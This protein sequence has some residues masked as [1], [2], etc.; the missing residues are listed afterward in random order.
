MANTFKDIIITPNRSSN[1]VDPKIEFRGGNVSVNTSIS[2]VVYPESNGTLSFEGSAG[3]LFSITNDLSGIIFSVN[4]ISGLPAIEVD[5]NSNIILNQFAGNVSIGTTNTAA[6]KLTVQGTVS[7]LLRLV[8]TSAGGDVDIQFIPVDSANTWTIGID[9]SDADKFKIAEHTVLGTAK[10]Y[11]TIDVNG[12]VSIG[13]SSSI[14]KFDV[15]FAAAR[16]VVIN[17][18]NSILTLKGSNDSGNPENLRL[19]ADSLLFH[20]GGTGSG[21]ERMRI[22]IGGNVMIGTTSAYTTGGTAGLTI[23][24]A[25][26]ALS[27]GANSS[28]M[29]YVRHLSDGNFQFQTGS[30]AGGANAGN[31]HLQPYG[32][33]VAIGTTSPTY[34]L[35]VLGAGSTLARFVGSAS[36]DALVRIIAANYGTEFD[37]RLFL[38]EN[39]NNGMTFEYDGVA[40]IGYIG[41]NDSI[42][43]TGSWSKRIQM[44][45]TGTEVAFMAGNVS[46]GTA[47]PTG[48]LTVYGSANNE[49]VLDAATGTSNYGRYVAFP[50][51]F[52]I[53]STGPGGS[54]PFAGYNFLPR[55]NGALS[56][57]AADTVWAASYGNNSRFSIIYAGSGTAGANIAFSE[58]FTIDTA[59]TANVFGDLIVS[60]GDITSTATA[61][62]LNTS[63]TTI[64]FGRLANTITIGNTTS[65]VTLQGD[66]TVSGGDILS[67]ATANLVNATTT[68]L[69]FAGAATTLRMGAAAGATTISGN[70]TLRLKAYTEAISNTVVSGT[71]NTYT[72]DLTVT[73]IHYITL[74]NA[75][76]RIT[77]TNVPAANIAQPVTLILRQPGTAANVVNFANT[78]HWSNGEVPVLSSG[79]ANKQDVL[80]FISVGGNIFFGAHALANV[81]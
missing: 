32:G 78:I 46:I 64:N 40:N 49:L 18:D 52:H 23:L 5:A 70:T 68:T 9:D 33:N 11:L 6:A 47:T 56:Y 26:V 61:N 55:A 73:N 8:D 71:T 30:A 44:S 79:I 43:P 42:D 53:G 76:V 45:R 20:T 17:Y 13:T 24:N 67:T 74:S 69:N 38:G 25:S 16:R 35:D 37:S 48:K 27:L 65:T 34:K 54:Y 10:D 59:G 75:N 31:I 39:D 4:D 7:P 29:M 50:L 62:L 19:I 57:A 66:L 36:T 72:A 2:A 60:G 80:T 41:M 81:G 58:L 3:Q 21:T 22:D 28:S 14:S 63:A 12:N 51:R 15:W 1:L 77:F